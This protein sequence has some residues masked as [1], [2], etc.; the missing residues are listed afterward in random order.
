MNTIIVP[1]LGSQ[2]QSS[3]RKL[4]M[5]IGI[6]IGIGLLTIFSFG[7]F[8][9]SDSTV[10]VEDFSV[11][12][13]SLPKQVSEYGISSGLFDN[14]TPLGFYELIQTI[15]KAEV[16]PR[17]KGMYIPIGES[18]MGFVKLEEMLE[19]LRSFKS[20][21]KFIYA[22]M[23]TASRSDY[24]MISLAD[25]I[26]MPK[27]GLA[28]L[29][30]PGVSAL[31]FKNMLAKIGV[32]MHVQQ[33]EEYKSAGETFSQERFTPPAKEEL[34][35]IIQSR[36]N[37][38]YEIISMQRKLTPEAVKSAFDMGTYTADSL[39]SHS[40]IDVFAQ[41]WEVKDMMKKRIEAMRKK[42]TAKT[43]TLE[44][45]AL[46]G[47]EDYA[48]AECEE[49]DNS[50]AD[51]DAS[52]AIVSAVGAIRSG[53]NGQPNPFDPGSQEIASGS[54]VKEL[55]RAYENDKV[56]A[57]I[58]R[59]DSPGGS[60][61]ASDEVWSMIQTLKKK[62][63]IYASMSDVA[64]SGGYYI[65]MA[66]DTIIAHPQT[67]TGSIGVIGMFP[68]VGDAMSKLGITMDTISTGASSQDMNFMLPMTDQRKK[69]LYDQMYPIYQRFVSKVANSRKMEFEQARSLAKGRV[70]LGMD[71]HQRKLI[72]TLGGIE[73]AINLAKKRIGIPANKRANIIAYP[74]TKDFVAEL[75]SSIS[76]DNDDDESAILK[77]IVGNALGF[78]K[79]E[80][81][82]SYM[83]QELRS[84]LVYAVNAFAIS[85][86]EQVVALMPYLPKF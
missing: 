29:S 73:L 75:L 67:I 35:V 41:E 33:F 38:M 46:I 68:L 53:T 37:R 57:V 44:R 8:F 25:S 18:Q 66:C 49:Y 17:I 43:D 59:I 27:E 64:A 55:K 3:R 24:M 13:L 7:M 79:A 26:F 23:E 63:P 54:L 28:E 45:L 2:K 12:Q 81:I 74:K 9:G 30:A 34:N 14:S 78:G 22:Y 40:L 10:E 39:K 31:F 52:I 11:L 48:S 5:I 6:V 76:G 85:K 61:I 80:P 1:P 19:A 56:K 42:E 71:A 20:K 84:G 32:T 21:G 36:A 47:L 82:L 72:D 58:L 4:L 62:K 69:K 65:P 83:P 77:Q 51:E 60:V 86:K 16:D 50:L 15:R 70:W